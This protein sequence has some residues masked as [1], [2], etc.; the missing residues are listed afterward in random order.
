[1]STTPVNA[2]VSSNPNCVVNPLGLH[3]YHLSTFAALRKDNQYTS[4]G[5]VEINRALP[6]TEKSQA[7]HLTRAVRLHVE[8]KNTG[9]SFTDFQAQAHLILRAYVRK[10]IGYQFAKRA[11]NYL[12]KLEESSLTVGISAISN[13]LDVLMQE[14]K[15]ALLLH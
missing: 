6:D 3:F 5:C 8:G 14:R 2:R 1:M 9:I 11:M 15:R 13:E 7:V 12:V 4:I 10:L